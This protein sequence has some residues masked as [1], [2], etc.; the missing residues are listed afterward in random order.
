[1]GRKRSK[2]LTQ[3]ELEE[4]L[5]DEWAALTGDILHAEKY[6]EA[7][8]EEYNLA[9]KQVRD[10]VAE[11][12]DEKSQRQARLT[13]YREQIEADLADRQNEIENKTEEIRDAISRGNLAEAETLEREMQE[14]QEEIEKVQRRISATNEPLRGDEG[15][16]KRLEKALVEHEYYYHMCSNWLTKASLYIGDAVK[17]LDYLHR[18]RHFM[19][20]CSIDGNYEKRR[21]DAVLADWRDV[22]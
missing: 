13:E 16:Y 10:L 15:I 14:M 20:E 21:I 22:E 8:R 4:F 18:H 9:D 12:N 19:F 1:M 2:P 5:V 3:K 11:Y 17:E 6:V 7:V